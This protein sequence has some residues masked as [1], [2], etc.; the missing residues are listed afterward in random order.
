M[1]K[2][3]SLKKLKNISYVLDSAVHVPGTNIR[4]GIDPIIGLIPGIGDSISSLISFY[5]IL[6]SAKM[7]VSHKTLIRMMGNVGVDTL[8]GA[9]PF[10]GDIFDIGWK[11]NQRNIAL[12]EKSSLTSSKNEPFK[13]IVRIGIILLGILLLVLIFM[14]S[15]GTFLLLKLFSSM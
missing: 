12:L 2:E 1:D 7:G 11:A 5:I 3:K 13:R 10:I 4:L 6:E 15:L 8:I 14:I 9:V